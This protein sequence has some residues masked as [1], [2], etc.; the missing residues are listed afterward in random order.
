MRPDVTSRR[1]MVVSLPAKI[2]QLTGIN[3]EMVRDAPVFS[4]VANSFMA[5]M[6]NGIFFAHNVNFN[7]GFLS[8][9]RLERR[10]RFPKRC[11]RVGI[12]RR[13]LG[14]KSYGLG[15][16]CAIYGIELEDHHRALC[17]ARAAASLL[18]LINRKREVEVVTRNEIA[19]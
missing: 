9:E 12:R 15:K 4:E 10:F 11:T 3:N 2:V 8:Y 1:E 13:Y 14:H 17:D 6:G 16:L 19:A 18:N 7:N 5:F